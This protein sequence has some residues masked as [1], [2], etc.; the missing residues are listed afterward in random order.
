MPLSDID[1]DWSKEFAAQESPLKVPFNV[2]KGI[3]AEIEEDWDQTLEEWDN[4]CFT[5]VLNKNVL[6]C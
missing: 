4:T 5:T 1:E 3:E 2:Y 6:F